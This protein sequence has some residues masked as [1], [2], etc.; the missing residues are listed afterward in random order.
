MKVLWTPLAASD[1]SQAVN[2]IA[3][4]KPDAATRVAERIY[5]QIQQLEQ[6]P[7]RGRAGQRAG[8]YELVFAPW[9]YVAVYRING[10]RIR[11]LRIRHTS[12]WRSD[13]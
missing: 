11:I 8:T 2:Y 13:R 3:Q 12:R 9:Q 6:M 4:D 1:L 5:S 10:D 7:Y